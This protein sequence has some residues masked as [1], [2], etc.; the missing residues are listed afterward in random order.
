VRLR[1]VLLLLLIGAILNIL[2]AW[3]CCLNAD[4]RP[5]MRTA[6]AGTPA[7][8]VAVEEGWPAATRASRSTWLGASE[9]DVGA[10]APVV[11]G[12]A[13]ARPEFEFGVAECRFGLP[14]RSMEYHETR[15]VVHG[16]HTWRTTGVWLL[17]WELPGHPLWAGF[18][19]N[20]P[21]YGAGARVPFLVFVWVKAM[22][23]TGWAR[24]RCAMR[25]P[26]DAECGVGK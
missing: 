23:L 13:S 11:R 8:P 12:D 19:V 14:L 16:V 25:R 20:T 4:L 2:V 5:Q 9:D 3:I 21:L 17:N 15:T 1:L 18:A 22:I 26:A 24:V 10:E 7:W 6:L